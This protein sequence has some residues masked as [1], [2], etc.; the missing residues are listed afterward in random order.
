MAKKRTIARVRV[1]GKKKIS[2]DKVDEILKELKIIESELRGVEIFEKKLE[3]EERK[4]LEKE[5]SIEKEEK[6]IQREIFQLGNFT[7]RRKHLLE[8][9]R[10]TAGAF[11][12]VGLG[13]NLLSLEGLA[14]N[15]AWANI[16][17]ILLFILIISAL[18]IY[19]NEHDFIKKEG[20]SIVWKKLVML[21]GIAV[22]VELLALGLFGGWPGSTEVLIKM[23]IIGSYAAMAGAVSFSII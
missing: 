17:G 16:I 18:L 10:G 12:G 23:L 9:I 14:N 6:K 11:L 15:L 2:A 21:Y 22:V 7:F 3:K 5:E 1:S 8:I 19:K 4:V 20:K 13:R